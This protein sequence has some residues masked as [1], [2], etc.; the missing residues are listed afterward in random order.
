MLM[1]RIARVA[2]L[3]AVSLVIGIS[4]AAL[5]QTV[6]MQPGLW[7]DVATTTA[8]EMPGAPPALV[9]MMIGK[10]MTIRHC[11]TDADAEQGPQAAMKKNPSCAI[12][13][14]MEASGRFSSTMICKEAGG[15]MTMAS[16]GTASP[17]AFTSTSKITRTGSQPM[18][19]TSTTIGRRVA[20]CKS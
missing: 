15:T 17:A 9:K 20:A 4:A 5:A 16:S 7:E 3:T 18:T 8:V 10:V 1:R 19:I 14:H 6:K 2:G 12:T 13:Y 11:L